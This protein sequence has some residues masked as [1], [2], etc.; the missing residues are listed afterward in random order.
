MVA[1]RPTPADLAEL[2]RTI[3]VGPGL[4]H[5][6]PCTSPVCGGSVRMEL[7][8]AP[9][10]SDIVTAEWVSTLVCPRCGMIISYQTLKLLAH[11]TELAR[12]RFNPIPYGQPGGPKAP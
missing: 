8:L 1:D 11:L 10:P 6:V 5:G 7:T 9:R 2:V 3:V 12:R 4:G